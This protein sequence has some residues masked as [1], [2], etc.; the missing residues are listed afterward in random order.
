MQQFKQAVGRLVEWE[1]M[2]LVQ[3]NYRY[4]FFLLVGIR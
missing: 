3:N 1:H 4:S 2:G